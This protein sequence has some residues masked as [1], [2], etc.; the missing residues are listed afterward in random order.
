MDFAVGGKDVISHKQKKILEKFDNFP[1]SEKQLEI[2]SFPYSSYDALI[3]DGAVRSGKTSLM[4]VAFI[5][6]A[7]REFNGRRFG[8]CGKTVGSATENI[9]IPYL[10]MTRT[11]RKYI[12]EGVGMWQSLGKKS[13]RNT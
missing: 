13:R 11:K 9:I 12:G 3:C 8:I 10:S 1:I 6:W 4:M 2:L 5:D 7:M